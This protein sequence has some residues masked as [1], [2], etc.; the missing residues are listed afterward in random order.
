MNTKLKIILVLIIVLQIL[1]LVGFVIYQENLKDTGT[2]IILQTIPL[3]PRDLLRGE[4]VELRYEISGITIENIKCYRLCLGYDLED[5]SNRPKSREDFLSSIEGQDVY[6]LLTKEPYRRENL[7]ISSDASWYV[8][9]VSDSFNFGNNKTEQIESIVIKGRIEKV[10]EIFTGI[11][12][13]IRISVDYGI[14]QYF[15]E[16]GKGR[17]VEDADD[18]K[19]EVNIANNG[20]AFITELIVDGMYLSELVSD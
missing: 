3:D 9:D 20:K 1:S 4:Y 5:K 18:V 2:K 17:V 11:D 12:S 15:L 13:V 16:E 14:E 10:E 7:S 19:V 6:V 8:Y